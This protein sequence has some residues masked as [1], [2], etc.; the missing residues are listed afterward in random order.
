M[1]SYKLIEIY[2]NGFD[3]FLDL[4]Q[5]PKRLYPTNNNK[6]EICSFNKHPV[7]IKEIIFSKTGCQDVETTLSEWLEIYDQIK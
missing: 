5:E 4:N 7:K 3:W 2:I 1:N 6:N